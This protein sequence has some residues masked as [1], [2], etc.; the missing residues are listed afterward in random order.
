MVVVLTLT[1]MQLRVHGTGYRSGVEG[2]PSEKVNK[3]TAVVSGLHVNFEAGDERRTS[4]KTNKNVK[5]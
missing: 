5:H 1:R 2:R 3:L 4:A